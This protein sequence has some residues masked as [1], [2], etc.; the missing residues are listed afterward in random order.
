ML[1]HAG[2]RSVI[3]DS[4]AVAQLDALLEG[5]EPSLFIILPEMDEVSALVQRWPQTTYSSV[6]TG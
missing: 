2:C 5:F 6:Q 3:V 4:R 1:Q